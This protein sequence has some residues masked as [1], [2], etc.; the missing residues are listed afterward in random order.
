MEILYHKDLD[1]KNLEDKHP[2]TILHLINSRFGAADI[3]KLPET[4][5]YRVKLDYSSRLI[6]KFA[7]YSNKT[8]I[9][10]L[11]FVLNHDYSKSKFLRGVKIDEDKLIPLQNQPIAE[12]IHTSDLSYLNQK[13]KHFHILDKIISF[14]DE[15]NEALYLRPPLILIGS[16]G[17]GKTAL[18]LEKLKLLEGNILYVTLSPFLAEHA[19][20]LYYSNQYENE[21]QEIDFLSYREFLES[22]RIPEGNV[23]RYEEFEK[24]FQ[25]HRNHSG[26][27]DSH[28]LYEEFNG[29]L[30]G[31]SI[32][33]DF[34][35]REDYLGLG[36]KQSIFL[37]DE[38]QQAYT[39]FEKF[40]QYLK[41]RKL[42]DINIISHQ[43]L[44]LCSPRYD[45]IVAD[46]V[47]DYTN[48]QIFLILKSLRQEGNFI[49]CG[50]SNQIV[51][52]N[53]FSW[54]KVKTLFYEHF[55]DQNITRIL[56]TNYRNSTLV[57]EIANRLLKIK[58]AR[59]GSIDRE[60]TYLINSVS[61]RQGEM[62]LLEDSDKTKN[63]FNF[64]TR[65]STRFAVIV[66][67]NEDK[68]EA[69]RYFNTPLLFSVQEAKG[70]EY[71]NIVL[72]N[73]IGDNEKPF[74]E[75][76]GNI[77]LP[78]INQQEINYSRAKDKTD[79]SLEV[80][81]FYIN[82]LYVAMTRAISNLYLI[83]KNH[84]HPLL[85]LLELN[86]SV[87]N[88]N[89][90][91]QVSSKDEWQREAQRLEKQG[92]AEQAELIRK[93]ILGTQPVPWRVLT[94][95]ELESL[96]AEGLNPEIYNKKAKD[97][98]FDYALIYNDTSVIQ[99]LARLNYK[100]AERPETERSS[101]FRRTYVN[102]TVE[103]PKLIIPLINKYG[104]DF[105]NEFNQTPLMIAAW[106][107]NKAISEYLLKL[108]AKTELVDSLGKN[109]L[110]NALLQT[111][112]LSDYAKNKLGTI[113]P[114]VVTEST[115]VKID[116]HLVK[117]NNHKTEYLL[118]S[119]LIAIQRELISK[120]DYEK[121]YGFTAGEIAE[122]FES[123]P[124]NA[125]PEYRKSQKYISAVLSRNEITREIPYN[126]KLF[127]RLERGFYVINPELEIQVN[128]MWINVYELMQSPKMTPEL[129]KKLRVQR[130][131]GFLQFLEKKQI[132][133]SENIKKEELKGIW[134][135]HKI[136]YLKNELRTVQ[137]Q[138]EDV[139]KKLIEI[140]SKS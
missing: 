20:R 122:I 30:T 85:S 67:R 44:N 32:E 49:L 91:Q 73:F 97:M 3:K 96:I 119:L 26:I 117:I 138:S 110:Q 123:Y 101:L 22:I 74:L 81:K 29:V 57:T 124:E 27:S 47:Q 64:K 125:L 116:N 59:F 114:L 7:R 2:Q 83:E 111:C 76:S 41:E 104:V 77:N 53:F 38:R 72:Y 54:S 69:S 79:K 50:D 28:K 103:N 11:E 24:W 36:V 90:Q 84:K 71:E 8:Y 115:N 9:L 33:K 75:I 65:Q 100:R 19:S 58:N 120:D 14:D 55:A 88:L 61:N 17:S 63:E 99:K 62:I 127:L 134:N 109:A 42:Y 15:Q 137:K 131:S 68:T 102:Y 82:S 105:R 121:A 52:P 129:N 136:T 113:Y 80:Y 21:N 78:E 56:K 1:I 126:K 23:I 112:F 140:R 139:Y 48:I 108:G 18:A 89:L 12:S 93:S 13:L 128:N 51:H 46:E 45:F 132:Q 94:V 31:Y 66:M 98:L 35:S 43:W 39:L 4:D 70:L 10:L 40:L 6:F 25:P 107:G 5:L 34:L 135:N 118:L 133:F 37:H 60:S 86:A 95:T 16:A 92:R 106:T 87:Q 130:L